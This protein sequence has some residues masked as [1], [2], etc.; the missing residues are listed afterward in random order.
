MM[1]GQR[2]LSVSC[3]V[4]FTILLH[5]SKYLGRAQE[6]ASKKGVLANGNHSLCNKI[7]E[8][9][10]HPFCSFV[11]NKSFYPPHTLGTD[12]YQGLEVHV[13][14]TIVNLLNTGLSN[15]VSP[16]VRELLIWMHIQLIGYVWKVIPS[17]EVVL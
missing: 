3:H 10:S 2:L 4:A 11:R 1:A 15:N 17:L 5:Q 12:R 13:G 8:V 16:K 14:R 6:H 9:L 7:T